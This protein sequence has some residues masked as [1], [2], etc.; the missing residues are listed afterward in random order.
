ME[1]KENKTHISAL[2]SK[3][4][5]L[6]AGHK[7]PICIT[8]AVAALCV[9]VSA[10]TVLALRKKPESQPKSDSLI[11]DSESAESVFESAAEIEETEVSSAQESVA[12]VNSESSKPVSSA[13]KKATPKKEQPASS[14]QTATTGGYKYNSNSDID[15]NIFLDALIYTGYNINKHR[16]DGRMWQY[17]LA[18]NKR[19]L[20][21][22]S[23]IT[24]GGGSSGY[25]T[26]Q[27]KPDIKYFEKHG[28]VCAS[29][30]T[31]VY[32]NY[33]PNVAGI[34]TSALPKPA[35]STSA[36]DW[37]LALKQWVSKGYSRKISFT[38]SK[39]SAGFVNFKPSEKI[40]IGSIVVFCD[41]RN[42]SDYGSHV[43]IYAGYKNNYNWIFH[44]GN[45]NGPEFCAVERMNFGHDP[46]WPIAV[47]TPPENIRMS[48]MLEVTVTD[49]SGKP[50]SGA[51]VSLK[52]SKTGTVIDL[53]MSGGK[54]LTKEGLTYGDY[55]LSFTVPAGYNA[56]S[57][58]KTLK[59]TTANNSKNTVNITLTA[60]PPVPSESPSS[61]ISNESSSEEAAA[62]SDSASTSQTE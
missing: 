34:D 45:K 31:Y 3:L 21:Y 36:N 23:N 40:P 1:V 16:A 20:G 57:T 10:G 42:R 38:A 55:T 9:T 35:R 12:S 25:E 27:G 19:G 37:Y 11:S 61:D 22:L 46:Q 15:D 33:L 49:N 39:T 7:I 47:I 43:A 24:Y 32:F 48:A 60:I 50:V 13:P 6:W 59:L 56:E 5:G 62:D 18:A 2:L 14:A 4:S 41:S 28:L 58:V 52:N 26:S 30:V 8:A 53:G 51:S 54:A 29:Y 44:V 17:I